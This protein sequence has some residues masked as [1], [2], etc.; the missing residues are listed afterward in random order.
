[1]HG[2][3]LGVGNQEKPKSLV[4]SPPW[5]SNPETQL[6]TLLMRISQHAYSA[7]QNSIYLNQPVFLNTPLPT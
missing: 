7:G 2:V 6:G 4:F 5:V 3:H 1:M